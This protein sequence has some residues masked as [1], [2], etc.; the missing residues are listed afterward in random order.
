MVAASSLVAGRGSAGADAS[1]STAGLWWLGPV[2]LVA[3][4]AMVLLEFGKSLP[5]ERWFRRLADRATMPL[6]A[7]SIVVI[8]LSGFRLAEII[9]FVS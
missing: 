5:P 1:L 7:L 3:V 6:V 8:L 4:V 2:S 9:G